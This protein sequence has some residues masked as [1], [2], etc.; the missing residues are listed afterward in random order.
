MVAATPAQ[1]DQP[2]SVR[3]DLIPLYEDFVAPPRPEL[4]NHETESLKSR[5][6]NLEILTEEMAHQ[7]HKS[8]QLFDAIAERLNKLIVAEL[9]I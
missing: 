4:T 8:K 7:L 2:M 5:V 1:P 6:Q 9:G 3:N